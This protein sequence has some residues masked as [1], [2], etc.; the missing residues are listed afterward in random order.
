MGQQCHAADAYCCQ[1][2]NA[3]INANEI[4]G[5]GEKEKIQQFI[6]K[7]NGMQGDNINMIIGNTG[8]STNAGSS[9][10][11]SILQSALDQHKSDS[12]SILQNNEDYTFIESIIKQG[13]YMTPGDEVEEIKNM[14]LQDGCIFTG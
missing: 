10:A 7:R 8:R 9:D 14:Q 4:I 11:M 3:E 5:G 13:N 12:S 1:G 6:Q 2:K